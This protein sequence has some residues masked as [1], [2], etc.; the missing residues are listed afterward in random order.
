MRAEPGAL[1]DRIQREAA[2]RLVPLNAALELTVRCDLA[3]AHCYNRDR[4][5]PP[6][7]PMGELTTEEWHRVMGEL[8][9]LGSLFLGFTGGEPMLRP[10]FFA[11][12]GH[13]RDLAL[14]VR[15]LSNGMRIDAAVAERLARYPNLDGVS[16]SLYGASPF[17]H[18]RITGVVGSFERTM[19][20]TGRLKAAGVSVRLK[21]GIL[22]SN[23]SDAAAMLAFGRAAGFKFQADPCVT[24]RHDGDR[25][26]LAERVPPDALEA[27]Y[28]G[29]LRALLPP[30]PSPGGREE[31]MC[32][33]ARNIVA[34]SSCGE[35][36]PCIAFPVPAGNV[37]DQPLAEI[38]RNSPVLLRLRSLA[39]KD[40]P[41]C[42]S[43]SLLDV[44]RRTPCEAFLNAGAD[45]AADAWMCAEAEAIRKATTVAPPPSPLPVHR[46]LDL[47]P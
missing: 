23:V 4:A 45:T 21:F 20:A 42:A 6:P 2:I 25:S 10:D 8:R 7:D 36:H 9:D 27:L 28:A 11:L 44:C 47:R 37:R 5:G 13:A 33:T 3:C 18:D 31:L 16:V 35:V 14:S 29:P 30:V 24:S 39:R 34:I 26:S 12:L 22:R 40:F 32:N 19:A 41:A 1:L 17:V 38:W 43:C 15:V 46:T